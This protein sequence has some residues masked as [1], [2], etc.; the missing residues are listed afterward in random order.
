MNVLAPDNYDKKLDEICNKMFGAGEEGTGVPLD[1]YNLKVVVETIF[2]K[3]SAEKD[4]TKMY[5]LLCENL[6]QFDLYHM[7][8]QKVTRRNIK[9]SQFRKQLLEYCRTS[10][11]QFYPHAETSE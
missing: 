6:T 7:G 2:R 1:D 11:V 4:Y 9:E 3:A 5:S 8:Y 10:F